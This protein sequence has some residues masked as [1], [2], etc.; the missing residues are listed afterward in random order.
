MMEIE[1]M[2]VKSGAKKIV[3]D[4]DEDGN[5]VGLSFHLLHKGAPIFYALPTKYMGV[6][7]ALKN[8]TAEMRKKNIRAGKIKQYQT[9]EHAILVSWRILKDW[10][11]AQMAF[12]EAEMSE[13]QEV[14]FPY[15]VS[16]DGTTIYQFLMGENKHLLLQE[17][18]R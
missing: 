13:V 8:S 4:Y 6:W 18:N 16:S 1:K 11:E 9:K 15:A 2:L 14:F 17:K 5:P 12:V 7:Q 10:V 3:K